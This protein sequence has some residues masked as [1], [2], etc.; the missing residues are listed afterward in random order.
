MFA[1]VDA[2]AFIVVPSRCFG[3]NGETNLLSYSR[4]MMVWLSLPIEKPKKPGVPKFQ[5]YFKIKELCQQRGVI[6]LSSNYELYS[7]LSAK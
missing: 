3:P 1:L 2:N 4:I 7:D 6:A 5:P